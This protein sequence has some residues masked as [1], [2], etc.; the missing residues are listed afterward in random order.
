LS[1]FGRTGGFEAP[2]NTQPL[3]SYRIWIAKNSVFSH[4]SVAGSG[5]KLNLNLNQ[6]KKSIH[7][8]DDSFNKLFKI[9]L[10][11]FWYFYGELPSSRR[12][13]ALHRKHETSFKKLGGGM[14][15]ISAFLDPDEDPDSLNQLNPD[16]RN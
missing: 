6:E 10:Y 15:A 4:R 11:F 9:F 12:S 16:P 5:F 2:V 8:W 3:R 13:P 14:V 1:W 7:V